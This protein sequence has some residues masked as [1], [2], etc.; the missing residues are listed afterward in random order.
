MAKTLVEKLAQAFKGMDKVLKEGDNGR[1]PY[2]RILDIANE[3]R[4]K[5]LAEGVLII[6]HDL[7]CKITVGEQNEFGRALVSAQVL[8]GV[9][10][11][12]RRTREHI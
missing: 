3:V 11:E 8:T 1:Y 9:C 5:L 7:E 4:E 6:P 10:R 2:L 12:R